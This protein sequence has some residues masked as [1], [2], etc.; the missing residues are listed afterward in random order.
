MEMIPIELMTTIPSIVNPTIQ[1]ISFAG[2]SSGID[3]SGLCSPRFG[4]CTPFTPA[5]GVSFTTVAMKSKNDNVPPPIGSPC[6][7]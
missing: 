5:L 6:S 4:F 2:V 3:R 1:Y 7:L